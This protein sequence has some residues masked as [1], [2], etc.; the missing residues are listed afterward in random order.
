MYFY[1]QTTN[2]LHVQFQ[3]NHSEHRY[4]YCIGLGYVTTHQHQQEHQ[5]YINY[6]KI[7]LC[8]VQLR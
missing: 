5:G 4:T 6:N 7:L 1:T 2:Y 8:I 3:M